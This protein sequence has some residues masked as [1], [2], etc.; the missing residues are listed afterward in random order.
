MSEKHYCISPIVIDTNALAHWTVANESDDIWKR[1]DYLFKCSEQNN[2]QLVIPT[3]VVAEFLV[4]T[5]DARLLVLEKL[6]QTNKVK[7]V[8]F[9]FKAAME[10]AISTANARSAGDKRYG[11]HSNLQK[12]KVDEQIVAIAKVIGAKFIVS[13]DKDIKNIAHSFGIICK[14]IQDLDL[15]PSPPQGN[16]FP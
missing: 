6:R 14:K 16:F 12:I 7:I 13:D 5:L 3:P 9:D 10:C 8:S 1:L 4:Y 15:P 2:Q 11:G